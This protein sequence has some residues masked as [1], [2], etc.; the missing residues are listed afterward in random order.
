VGGSDKDTPVLRHF[1]PSCCCDAENMRTPRSARDTIRNCKAVFRRLGSEWKT[2]SQASNASIG[3]TRVPYE[4][5]LHVFVA[6]P[7]ICPVLPGRRFATRCRRMPTSPHW[8][9]LGP[10]E[11]VTDTSTTAAILSTLLSQHSSKVHLFL[12]PNRNVLTLCNS[13]AT[14]TVLLGPHSAV[15]TDAFRRAESTRDA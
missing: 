2:F 5:L 15:F 14:T 3:S 4:N 1:C 9:L 6:L 13:A 11:S 7:I 12:S 8:R 10:M